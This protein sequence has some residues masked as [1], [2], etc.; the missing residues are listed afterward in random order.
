MAFNDIVQGLK[1]LHFRTKERDASAH[2]MVYCL[3]AVVLKLYN[4]I[5]L[6]TVLLLCILTVAILDPFIDSCTKYSGG[7]ILAHI[8][9][10]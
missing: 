3:F 2:I 1:T 8:K 9:S 7:S 5:A 10:Q 4:L 6:T